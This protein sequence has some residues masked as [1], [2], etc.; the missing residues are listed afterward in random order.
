[1]PAAK[2]KTAVKKTRK[3]TTKKSSAKTRSITPKLDMPVSLKEAK[4][5]KAMDR[6]V[7]SKILIVVALALL[8]YKFGPWVFPA[9]VDNKPISR[10]TLIKRLE[11]SYGAQTLKDLVNE[12]ILDQAIAKSDV[13][14]DKDKIQEQLDLAEEQFAQLGGLDE[15]LKQ[16]GMT[17]KELTK[18]ITTQLAVEEILQDKI[19]PS[20]EDI[21][22]EYDANLETFYLDKTLDE[23]SDQIEEQLKQVNLRDAFLE[24]FEGVEA[25]TTVKTFD[26]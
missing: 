24:W 5:P 8:I 2:K 10:F 15:A 18:Q 17:V 22:A 4:P 6:T 11:Q 23:V 13:K 1:M 21:Q 19:Q 7:M 14:V 25:D 26:L 20:D 3:S 16:R 12:A 9:A